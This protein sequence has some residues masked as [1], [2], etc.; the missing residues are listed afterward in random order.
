LTTE[1]KVKKSCI[2][3]KHRLLTSKFGEFKFGQYFETILN[4]HMSASLANMAK[5]GTG[6]FDE[7]IQFGKYFNGRTDHFIHKNIWFC[8]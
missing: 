1:N 8:T 3:N 5:F 4:T 2:D 6:N 7:F